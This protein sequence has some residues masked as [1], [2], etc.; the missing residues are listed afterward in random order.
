MGWRDKY[1]VHPAADVFPMMSDEELTALGEDI[2]KNGQMI[3]VLL[4]NGDRSGPVLIDGRNRLEAMERIGIADDARVVET[5]H[6]KDPV[7]HII[8]LNIRRRHLTKQQQ[9]ELIIAA[10]MAAKPPQVEEVSKGGRGKV[11]ET[12]TKAVAI[13]AD[14]GISE[15]TVKRG[16]AKAEG[17]TPTRKPRSNVARKLSKEEYEARLAAEPDED[18][19]WREPEDDERETVAD[20]AR[21]RKCGLLA[22]ASAEHA[23]FAD[24]GH[25][26]RWFIENA[27]DQI[28]AKWFIRCY[29]PRMSGATSA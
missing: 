10:V 14:L 21:R 19:D 15:S 27:P 9:T 23:G 25:H 6:C 11:N 13:A 3:P 22:C 29:G 26:V 18:E 28:D 12:K 16:F 24:A 8:T 2:K 7:T 1:K 5:L 4:W 20:E 17:R